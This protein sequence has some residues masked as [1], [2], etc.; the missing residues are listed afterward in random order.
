M[1]AFFA[2]HGM[3]S[4]GRLTSF[5][6]YANQY[7][8]PFNEI[9]GV[10][11]ELQNAIACAARVFELMEAEPQE[12]DKPDAIELTQVKGAVELKNVSFSYV[13]EQKLI[14]DFNLTVKPGQ[15]VAI[16]GPTGCGKTTVINLLMRFYDVNKCDRSGR[17]RHPQYD[18]SQPAKQYRYGASGD[19]A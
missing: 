8:K 4:V 3:L 10:I 6:S 2:I 11:T 12:P 1:G 17:H 13:P 19:M 7:T 14:R 18:K 9:S 5:L 16:V 15:R